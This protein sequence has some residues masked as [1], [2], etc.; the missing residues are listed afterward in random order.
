M[1]HRADRDASGLN[2][3]D[4]ADPAQRGRPAHRGLGVRLGLRVVP[5]G[6]GSAPPGPA[7]STRVPC[8]PAPVAG[9][10]VHCASQPDD[11]A[12]A[13]PYRASDTSAFTRGRMIRPNG[14]AALPW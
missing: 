4:H 5:A 9:A 11:V 3:T 2:G 6:H 14:G 13:V 10:A 7:A 8:G 1:V 12:Y